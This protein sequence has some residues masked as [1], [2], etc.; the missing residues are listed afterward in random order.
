[1]VAWSP[2]PAVH[3]VHTPVTSPTSSAFP[4]GG[5]V[6]FP[7]FVHNA[8]FRGNDFRGCRHSVMFRPPSL[9]ASQVLP[10]LRLCRRAAEAFYVRAERASLPPHAPDM[11]A[12]RSQ[13]IDGARTCTSLDSQHCRLLPSPIVPT[14]A[15][16][17]RRA[18]EAF[19]S[20]Q[21]ML[22]CLRMHRIC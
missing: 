15:T 22:R 17:R 3:Q 1:L 4:L 18:A 6:G 8:T 10:L 16:Y 9:F 14:A 19:T 20:E 13:A 2:T 12:V 11:L 5:W 7:L 21:N